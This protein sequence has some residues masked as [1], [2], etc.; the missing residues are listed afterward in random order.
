MLVAGERTEKLAKFMEDKGTFSVEFAY[1]S[2]SINLAQI[3]D[4]IISVDKML[5][6]YQ[7]GSI[8]IRSDMQILKD[9]LSQNGFFNANEIIFAVTES[10]DQKKAISYFEAA[11]KDCKFENY[12]IK[13]LAEKPSF[14]DIYNSIL[15]ISRSQNFKN[16]FVNVYRVERN[17]DSHKSYVGEDNKDVSIEPFNYDRL[18]SYEQAKLDAI[19]VESGVQHKDVQHEEEKFSNVAF[20]ALNIN[21]IYK[22]ARTEIVTGYSKTGVTTWT[23]AMALSTLYSQK[24]VT[25]I[26]FSDN[27]DC[28]EVLENNN[29]PFNQVPMIDMLRLYTPKP[30]ML[31]VCSAKSIKER[32]VEFEFLKNLYSK[33]DLTSGFVFIITPIEKLENT[34]RIIHN[35]LDQIFIGVAPLRADIMRLQQYLMP[36]EM[37]ADIKVFLNMRMHL[38]NEKDY[39][40]V[41][42]VKAMLPYDNVGVISPIE[43][44]N[45]N[46]DKTLYEKL[47]GV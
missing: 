38:M 2:L 29:I 8:S 39:L 17:S 41:S 36:Y 28:A 25:V 23:I 16:S 19:K 9:L 11:M 24:T 5:Y 7:P 20:G 43:F 47:L 22:T 46:V 44:S 33:E 30:N 35:D 10:S 32:S 15:G 40:D 4:S 13:K 12:S 27:C 3:K 34:F 6:L 42:N 21:S 18:A 14:S 37:E 31:N 45:F 26:D 1:E